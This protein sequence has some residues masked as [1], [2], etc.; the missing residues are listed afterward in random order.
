[1]RKLSEILGDLDKEESSLNIANKELIESQKNLDR[2]IAD[3]SKIEKNL[4]ALK[5]ELSDTCLEH[6]P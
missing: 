1:M 6:S 3:C 4:N 5:Q 2:I